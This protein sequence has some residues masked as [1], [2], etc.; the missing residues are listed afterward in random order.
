MLHPFEKGFLPFHYHYIIR[1]RRLN[2]IFIKNYFFA[3]QIFALIFVH[4]AQ[5][6]LHF[7]NNLIS[8]PVLDMNYTKFFFECNIFSLPTLYFSLNY[9]I[10]I[11]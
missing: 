11:L 10:I 5:N 6:F 1:Y 9:G 2:E 4:I 8:P 3:C 7:Y